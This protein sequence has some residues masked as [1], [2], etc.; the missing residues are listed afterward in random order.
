M[1]ED[2][3]NSLTRI[4]AYIKVEKLNAVM[5]ALQAKKISAIFYHSKGIGKGEKY[6]LSYGRGAGGTTEMA[7]SQRNTIIIVAR[8][9][10]VNEIINIIKANATT[11]T[12]GGGIIVTSPADE[13]IILWN[14]NYNWFK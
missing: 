8:N 7:Y 13:I 2:N 3:P 10:R 6:R 4:E 14:K 11:G 12:S 1:V 9:E 5:R